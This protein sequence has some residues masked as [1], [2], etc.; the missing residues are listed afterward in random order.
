M[1]VWGVCGE[2]AAASMR[3]QRE[4]MKLEAR[5][6]T[7]VYFHEGIMTGSLGQWLSK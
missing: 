6:R 5:N 7:V 3:L 2:N 1:N 4:Q